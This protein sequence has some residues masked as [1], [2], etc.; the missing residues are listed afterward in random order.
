VIYWRLGPRRHLTFGLLGVAGF[1]ALL[2]L[3]GADTSLWWARLILFCVG[4]SMAQVFVPAQ[5]ASFATISP[6]DTGRASTLYNASRQLGG[7]IGVALLTTTIVIVGPLHVVDA[8]RPGAIEPTSCCSSARRCANS[9]ARQARRP[10]PESPRRC[11]HHPI[12]RHHQTGH[13][14]LADRRSTTS[15]QNGPRISTKRSWRSGSH[16]CSQRQRS[17]A[18]GVGITS[19]S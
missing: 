14:Y 8:F 2:A 9:P 3:M 12:I 4:I 7:A 11:C 6:A 1:I 17:S 5:A 18:A 15:L 13:D 16:C 10:A 19:R